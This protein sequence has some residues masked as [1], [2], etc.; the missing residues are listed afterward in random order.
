MYSP[1]VEFGFRTK[2]FVASEDQKALVIFVSVVLQKQSI[3]EQAMN[4]AVNLTVNWKQQW[5]KFMRSNGSTPTA[6]AA[7]NK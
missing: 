6:S 5:P 7:C 4:M 1:I 3:N 2:C